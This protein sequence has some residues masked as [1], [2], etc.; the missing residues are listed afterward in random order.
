MDTLFDIYSDVH[1]LNADGKSVSPGKM[2]EKFIVGDR[3]C[4]DSRW[5]M[6]IIYSFYNLGYENGK[7][8]E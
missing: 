4:M 3:M 5:L 1:R 7:K 2:R 8:S 6:E